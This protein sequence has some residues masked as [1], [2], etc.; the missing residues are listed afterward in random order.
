[1]FQN[2]KQSYEVMKFAFTNIRDRHYSD[3][4]LSVG[5]NS[6]IKDKQQWVEDTHFID[7]AFSAEAVLTST[8]NLCFEQKYEKYLN[9][10]SKNFPFLGVK[11]SIYLNRLVSVMRT[12]ETLINRRL[13]W[14]FA[15]GTCQKVLFLI[16]LLIYIHE[17]Y[18]NILKISSPKT[19]SFQI[20]ILIFFIFLLKNIN[21]GT[22]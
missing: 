9:F 15:G 2:K 20:K 13:I 8:L 3:I 14:I 11:F 17:A 12:T 10:L 16:F 21:C 1:M 4:L 5:E 18:S 6:C 7:R 19:D 22:R